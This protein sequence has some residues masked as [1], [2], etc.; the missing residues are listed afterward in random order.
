M[1]RAALRRI[2]LVATAIPFTL[3]Q[4]CYENIK[5]YGLLVP[6]FS[7][8]GS[9]IKYAVI[10]LNKISPEIKKNLAKA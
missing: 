4:L 3:L 9:E 5:N 2:P 1:F 6:I 10:K 7:C 8:R